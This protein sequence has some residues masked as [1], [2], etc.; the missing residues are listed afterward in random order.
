MSMRTPLGRV[1]GHGSAKSGTHHFWLQ[2]LT[3]MANV[4]L[5]VVFFIVVIALLGRNHAAAVGTLGSPLVATLM[6]L[7]ILS[8]V[9]HMHLGMQVVIEDYVHDE[10]IKV[11]AIMGNTFFCVVVG[12]AAAFAILKLSFGV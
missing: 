12:L 11:L 9:R 6:L 10:G 4:P 5:T 2:R 1:R 3:A 8:V 7:T